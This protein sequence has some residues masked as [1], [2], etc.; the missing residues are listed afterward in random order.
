MA[1]Y[2]V[3]ILECPTANAASDGV[4]EKLVFGPTAVVARDRETAIAAVLSGAKLDADP[5][6]LVVLVRPFVKG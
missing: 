5:N 6:R 2:E 3:A 1:L 4:S